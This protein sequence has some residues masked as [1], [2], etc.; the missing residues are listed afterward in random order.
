MILAA[1]R[2]ERLKPFTNQLPKPLIEIGSISILDRILNL[3]NEANIKSL[4]VNTSYLGDLISR[5]LQKRNII[6]N[7][8]ISYEPK[9]LDTGG[10]VANA[11]PH[12][13]KDVFVV[14]NADV[15]VL[16]GNKGNPIKRLSDNWDVKYMDVL[17]LVC[18]PSK[19]V[20]YRG[21]CD[22]YLENMNK[23]KLTREYNTNKS[24]IFSGMQLLSPNIFKYINSKSFSLNEIYNIAAQNNRLWGLVHDGLW[25]HIG[26][27]QELEEVKNWFKNKKL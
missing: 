22:F 27:P 20:A 14:S 7:T 16:P 11:L 5:H 13:G 26:N 4:V 10:G 24:H 3:Y 17:L 8:V 6:P 9:R 2:G 19:T 21:S 12:L 15:V 23:G 18:I 1:G 25:F